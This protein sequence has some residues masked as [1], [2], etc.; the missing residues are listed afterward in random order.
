MNYYLSYISSDGRKKSFIKTFLNE[1]QKERYLSKKRSEGCIFREIR[2]VSGQRNER[3]AK[4]DLA[5]E[6]EIVSKK[7]EYFN[8]VCIYALIDNDE[9]VY[10]GQSSDVMGRLSA[11]KSSVKEFS[12]F[13]I[14]ERIDVKEEDV[15]EY[16]NKREMYYIKKLRPKY[17]KT[18]N[19]AINAR[20]ENKK[21][22]RQEEKESLKW[23]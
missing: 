8:S 23:F 11:H 19:R 5:L 9:V 6:K 7:R 1:Q 12:H 18:G 17:N 14:I 3:K 15:S 16:V 4:Y 2:D 22:K 13:S 10:I 20:K 21:I